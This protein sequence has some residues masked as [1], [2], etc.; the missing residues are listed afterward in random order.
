[1]SRGDG[2]TLIVGRPVE[3]RLGIWRSPVLIVA[4]SGQW[5]AIGT[6]DQAARWP[7]PKLTLT[8]TPASTHHS[9]KLAAHRLTEK[10]REQLAAERRQRERVANREAAKV[11]A[12][13]RKYAIEQ[14]IAA[15]DGEI[16]A[17]KNIESDPYEAQISLGEAYRDAMAVWV[18]DRKEARK[19]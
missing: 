2:P 4:A 3:L 13:S 10:W 11:A 14:E 8:D 16:E 7:M 1:M 19:A 15:I 5:L 17:M 6:L 12:E 18:R 9:I